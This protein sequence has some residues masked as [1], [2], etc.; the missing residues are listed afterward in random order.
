MTTPADD[1]YRTSAAPCPSGRRTGSL[2]GG[3]RSP[4]VGRRA[5]RHPVD[6][7]RRTEAPARGCRGRTLSA[8]LSRVRAEG[9][10]DG[11]AVRLGRREVGGPVTL[12]ENVMQAAN[13][14]RPSADSGAGQ[15]AVAGGALV[16]ASGGVA[17]Q[18]QSELVWV[19]RMGNVEPLGFPARDYIFPRLSP[20]GKRLT[21]FN[22]YTGANRRIWMYDF[23]RRTQPMP[24][25]PARRT[26]IVG[27]LDGRREHRLFVIHQRRWS[28]SV[29][30]ARDRQWQVAAPHHG[31]KVYA[32]GLVVCSAQD[33][34]GR[35]G[36]RR[37]LSIRSDDLRSP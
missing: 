1:E 23:A 36:W 35:S 19:D 9:C 28:E 11:C 32:T 10:A 31:Q 14:P 22:S 12:V 21:F 3:T 17:P 4:E 37:Y 24:L 13:M 18:P 33:L 5:D 30:E 27:D 34:V 29:H 16:Y 8:W 15:F 7:N 25:T 2:Y 6:H 20:D 26:R